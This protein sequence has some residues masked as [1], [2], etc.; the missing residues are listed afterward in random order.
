MVTLV[1]QIDTP[2]SPYAAAFSRDGTRLAVGG[3]AWYGQGGIMLLDLEGDHT[4]WLDWVDVLE[5]APKSM[6][7][8]VALTGV[9]ASG[10]TVSGLCFSDDDRFLAASMWSASQ[11]YA[12]T[13]LL[14]IEGL[15]VR[16]RQT[17]ECSVTATIAVDGR[18]FSYREHA[19]PTGVLL[20]DGH[21]ITR[22]HNSRPEGRHV[23]VVDPLPATLDVSSG[24]RLQFL[25]HHR[26][27]VVH[28]TA[29]TEA[30]GSR[31]THMLQ[32]DGTTAYTP[33]TEGL[34]LLDLQMPDAPLTILPVQA[35]G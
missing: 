18:T 29:I 14:E 7:R 9:P 2:W 23:L 16:P 17:F 28:N 12:P 34:A 11:R 15:G 6:S 1:R 35:L 13:M 21:L 10:P 32:P 30:G 27:V 22:R 20:N 4:G 8:H 19:T 31:G 33:A 25:T 5:V 24:S 3:G 26:L